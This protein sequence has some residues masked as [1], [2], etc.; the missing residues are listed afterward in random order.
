MRYFK[1][2]DAIIISILSKDPKVSLY[3]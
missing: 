2:F 3:G 1:I